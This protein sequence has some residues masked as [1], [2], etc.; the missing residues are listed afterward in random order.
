MMATPPVGITLGK[1]FSVGEKL[2]QGAQ[3]AVHALLFKGEPTEYVVKCAPVPPPPRS[4][5]PKA[6]RTIEK[7][8]SDSLYY[9]NLMACNHLGGLQKTMIPQYGCPKLYGLV[10]CDG[11]WQTG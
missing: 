3:A 10:E 1:G 9:E 5:N 4:K 2:G 11:E 6:K 8:N 7:I